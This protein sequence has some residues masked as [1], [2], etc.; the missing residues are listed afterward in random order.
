MSDHRHELYEIYDAVSN[1]DLNQLQNQA[2]GLRQD[3]SAAEG[4]IH[5]LERVIDELR[6]P[7][8]ECPDCG[9]RNMPEEQF[10]YHC[11]AE[12]NVARKR[13]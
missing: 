11:G 2:D 5:D 8:R 9:G 4:R 1:G 10:C 7:G 13:A 3:L 6:R 12:E